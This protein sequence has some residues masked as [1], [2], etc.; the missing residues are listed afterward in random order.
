M[1]L[2]SN[3]WELFERV[4]L[5]IS[6]LFSL[7]PP[8]TNAAF[9][10]CCKNRFPSQTIVLHRIFITI[11]F[12]VD[13]NNTA[14]I[15][16]NIETVSIETSVAPFLLSL[17]Q[18]PSPLCSCWLHK[19]HMLLLFAAFQVMQVC[20]VHSIY[21]DITICKPLDFHRIS[22][23]RLHE[24]IPNEINGKILIVIDSKFR[25]KTKTFCL[26]IQSGPFISSSSSSSFQKKHHCRFASTLFH[27]TL[28][29]FDSFA[30]RT[31]RTLMN[32]AAKPHAYS[33]FLICY[34]LMRER[35]S[36]ETKKSLFT[37]FQFQRM[38][39][40]KVKIFSS[41]EIRADY[42]R[43]KEKPVICDM[44]NSIDVVIWSHTV[45]FGQRQ[46]FI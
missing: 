18:S 13:K 19:R 35:E 6:F 43:W 30:L 12:F 29:C 45:F 20:S 2:G 22:R 3:E 5:Y 44:F 42:R 46:Q 10:K 27:L 28:F 34:T 38:W 1:I 26:G 41:R 14:G 40:E 24:W 33:H 7:F 23:D 36:S 32:A 4:C 9:F 17:L 21:V 8:L 16:S 15:M 39:K 11:F 31:I 37:H 25:W